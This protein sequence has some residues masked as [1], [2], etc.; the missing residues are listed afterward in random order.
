MEALNDFGF[1]EVG[2]S[3]GDFTATDRVVQ[4]GYPPFR[5]DLLTSIDGVE[6]DPAWVQRQAVLHDRV[7]LPFIGLDALKSNKRASD[8]PRDGRSGK[9]PLINQPACF[10]AR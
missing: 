1:G 5:I 9:P 3:V 4:L 2:L 8:R 10:P 7:S 6:F